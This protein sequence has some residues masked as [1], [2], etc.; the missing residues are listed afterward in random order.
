MLLTLGAPGGRGIG[1]LLPLGPDDSGVKP[2]LSIAG[3]SVGLGGIGLGFI[4]A[5]LPGKKPI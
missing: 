3:G 5:D 1:F 4:G 2:G